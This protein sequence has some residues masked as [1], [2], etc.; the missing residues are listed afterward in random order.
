MWSGEVH[1][2]IKQGVVGKK[3]KMEVITKI[4]YTNSDN[5]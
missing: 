3:R 1:V 2:F 4:K 5:V